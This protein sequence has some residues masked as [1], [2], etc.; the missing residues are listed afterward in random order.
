MSYNV[1]KS[2]IKTTIQ[3]PDSFQPGG[4]FSKVP[5]EPFKDHLNTCGC[6]TDPRNMPQDRQTEEPLTPMHARTVD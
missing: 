1:A 4:Y 2:M 3:S 6:L 5:P